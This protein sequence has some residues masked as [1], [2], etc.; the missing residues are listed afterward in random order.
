MKGGVEALT[1][2][3]LRFPILAM[4]IAPQREATAATIDD[5][6]KELS[7]GETIHMPFWRLMGFSSN[8]DERI[9][10]YSRR[11]MRFL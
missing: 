7:C 11:H 5:N 1:P 2:P 8:V 3:F 10:I 4:A 9:S 6:N